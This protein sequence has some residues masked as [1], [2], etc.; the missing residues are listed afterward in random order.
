[1]SRAVDEIVRE[2]LGPL[3][4]AQPGATQWRL[5]SWD[6]D[7]GITL[8]LGRHGRV[9]Y[10]E[11]SR[12]DDA[13]ACYARTVRFN[14]VAR[15][16]FAANEEMGIDERRVIDRLTALIRQR[17]GALPIV[18]RPVAIKRSGV[19]EIEVDRVLVSEGAGHFYVNPYVGCMVGCEF[20]WAGPN[21]DFSRELEQLPELPWGRW[22]DVKINAPAVLR[23]ELREHSPGI[24]RM[25]P[26]VTDPYQPLEKTFRIT[27][28]CLEAIADAG[29]SPV[30]LTREARV[31]E[32][33]EVL[34]RCRSAAVGLSIPTDDDSVRLAFEPGASPIEERFDALERCYRA[35]VRTFVVV[36][37]LL[38]MDPERLVARVAPFVRAVRLDRMH[39]VERVR[40]LYQRA[41]RLDALGDAFFDRTLRALRDGFAAR[42]VPVDDLDDLPRA[43]GMTS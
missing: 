8:S 1:M 11:I 32:D 30:I 15:L 5:L 43:L 14:I 36:Q 40:H 24:V 22:T 6:V 26:V 18:A 33:L 16:A 19:R 25:S 7:Q 20:C 27:R 9:L 39:S 38:P 35:G 17:E 13:Q 41:G 4:A 21:A 2:L 34:S 31:C 3:L 10:V 23:R 42:G 28:G 37:P 29:Y 12:R